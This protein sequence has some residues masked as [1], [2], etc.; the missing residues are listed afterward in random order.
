MPVKLKCSSP[1][2]LYIRYKRNKY[3]LRELGKFQVLV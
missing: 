3:A 1:T 2:R